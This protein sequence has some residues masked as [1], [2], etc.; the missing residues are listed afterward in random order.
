[1]NWAY[2]KDT[3]KPSKED[4]DF[5]ENLYRLLL[6]AKYIPQ[7]KE[8]TDKRIQGIGFNRK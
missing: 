7:V 4:D 5:P 2:H 1:M 6:I 3:E 8:K